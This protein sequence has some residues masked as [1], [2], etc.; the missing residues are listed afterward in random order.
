MLSWVLDHA[1]VSKNRSF[2]YSDGHWFFEGAPDA[3][4]RRPRLTG[5]YVTV[6]RNVAGAWKVLADIGTTD[7]PKK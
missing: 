4:G 7:P 3:K 6:W 2:G 5:H 1:E